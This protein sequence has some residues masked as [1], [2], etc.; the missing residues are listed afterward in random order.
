ME[1]EPVRQ[2]TIWIKCD[3]ATHRQFQAAC[4]LMGTSMQ[5]R[6]THHIVDTIV[7]ASKLFAAAA[8]A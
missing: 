6:M 7:E 8:T 2:T 1:K 4:V 3:P 5:D